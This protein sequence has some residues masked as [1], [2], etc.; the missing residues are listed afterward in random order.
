MVLQTGGTGVRGMM[1][2]GQALEA[3]GLEAREIVPVGNHELKRHQV[4]RLA[5]A[6]GDCVLKLYCYAKV[7]TVEAGAF[8]RAAACGVAVPRVLQGGALPDGGD[9]L[10]MSLIEGAP[11][12]TQKVTEASYHE[13]GTQ[14]GRLH[15]RRTPVQTWYARWLAQRSMRRMEKIRRAEIPDE[16]KAVLARAHAAMLA[17]LPG[18]DLRGT[19]FGLCHGDFDVRNVM[20]AEGR[21]TGVIDCEHA[22]Y[23]VTVRDLAQVYRKTLAHPENSALRAAF[24]AGYREHALLDARFMEAMPV[25]WIEDCMEACSWAYALAPDH[26]RASLRFLQTHVL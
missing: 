26:Y 11:L 1:E 7:R 2:A 8:A 14:I 23:G 9:Y 24:E 5:L 22:N 21:V 10:L 13:M 17:R 25:Y 19:A 6:D 20:A 3:L 4:Y 15:A 18:L 12:S 16:D